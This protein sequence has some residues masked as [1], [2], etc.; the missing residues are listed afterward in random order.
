MKL[1][2]E[3]KRAYKAFGKEE[4]VRIWLKMIMVM[5]LRQKYNEATYA[6]FQKVS[7]SP[8]KS[9]S[10]RDF[11]GFKPEDLN[12]TSTGQLSTSLGGETV[13][14]I[15]K[16]ETQKLIDKIQDSRKI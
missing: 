11:E 12:V 15:N 10:R 7:R 16:K 6:F 9:I 8:G 4:D 5:V 2:Q 13:F 3:V 14:S 1:I